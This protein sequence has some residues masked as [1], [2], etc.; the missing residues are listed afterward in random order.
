MH[1][2]MQVSTTVEE[3]AQAEK[4]ARALVEK[5]LAAC[6]QVVGPVESTYWWKGKI[7]KATEWLLLIK[8]RRE[9]YPQLEQAIKQLHPYETPEIV[10]L[11]ITQ[12]SKE[13]LDWIGKVTRQAAEGASDNTSRTD[14]R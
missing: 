13:Y 1:E 3:G 12:G 7:E 5:R 10:A 9:L 14:Q 2:Y 11:P 8:T 6:V 4:I